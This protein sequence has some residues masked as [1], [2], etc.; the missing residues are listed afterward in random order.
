MVHANDVK[1]FF[2]NF[3]RLCAHTFK[4]K[5][6][7]KEMNGKNVNFEAFPESSEGGNW[8]VIA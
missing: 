7:T 1:M 4:L 3:T 5:T 2:L 8:G 6:V